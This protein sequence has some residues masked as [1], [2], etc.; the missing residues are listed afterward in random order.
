MPIAAG[1]RF[2]P[3]E[4][5][6]QIGAGGMGEVYRAT[7][8]NLKRDV[9]IKVLPESIAADADRIA[10]FKR[11]AEVLA[12]LNHAHIAQIYGLE[13][14]DDQTVIVMELVDGPTLA[15]RIAAGPVSPDEA[16]GIARQ[17]ANALEAAHSAQVVHRDLK[18]ANVK[19]KP[20][21]TV[22]VLDFGIAKAIDA[23]AISGG[24]TPVTTTPAVTET[25]VILGTAAYMSPEQARGRPVDQRTDI[26]AFGC[27]LFEMLTGQPAFG[28]EDV[29]MT[30][31]R[32]LDRDTDLSSM[33]GTISPAVRHTIELC[34]EKDPRQRLSDIR[35]VQLALDGRLDSGL[36]SSTE[37]ATKPMPLWRRGLPF[38]AGLVLGGAAI[39]SIMW[40]ATEREPVVSRITDSIG[41]LQSQSGLF[42]LSA[43]AAT[44]SRD[45]TRIGYLAGDPVTIHVRRIDEFDA[46]AVPD[47]AGRQVSSPPCF[48]PDGEWIA[49]SVSNSDLRKAPVNGGRGLTLIE[50]VPGVD[51]CDWGND[52]NIYFGTNAGI[53]RVSESG[54]SMETLTAVDSEAGDASHEHPQLL[55]GGKEVLFS[56][57]TGR[58]ELSLLDVA[59]VD[60][61]TKEKTIVIEGVGYATFAPTGPRPGV[62]H[63]VYGRD[64]ALFAAPF[65]LSR[66]TL[67]SVSP[68]LD[69][70]MGV[71][72]LTFASVSDSGTLAYVTGD[73]FTVD[74]TLNWVDRD[75]TVQ[76][77]TDSGRTWGEVSLSPDGQRIASGE[78]DFE[79]LTS[80]L[81]IYE[82]SSRRLTRT[83]FDGFNGSVVWTPNGERLIYAGLGS[84]AAPEPTVRS[85][86]ADGSAPPL[87]IADLERRALFPTSLS[88]DGTALIGTATRV[89]SPAGNADIFLLRLADGTMADAPATDDDLEFPIETSFNE[90]HAT[91]SP[92]GHWLAYA[93]NESGT[94]Q[95]Y[96]V[97]YPG[98]GGKFQVST[99]GGRQPRW[100]PDGGELFYLEGS[101]M[102]VV[103]VETDAGFRAENPEV[104]FENRDL[105]ARSS[106]NPLGFQYAVA[107][108]GESFLMLQTART[109]QTREL[110]IVQNWFE[111][112]ERL[113]PR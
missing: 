81:W 96:V 110:R 18:P 8:T 58:T 71:A 35:D 6:E 2:G 67:G 79:N 44:I 10:R 3:Y 70:V 84:I 43:I 106:A 87:T 85:V 14:T 55:P 23:Q 24:H 97:P 4:I 37:S 78:G 107:P 5:V 99:G 66:R 28:G 80:D 82:F 93:S 51:L 32:V 36:T 61:E 50:D 40:S 19:I 109:G 113:A 15:D 72:G 56:I 20:D 94:E 111:E 48:S 76:T 41:Q 101:R 98:P 25:G 39:A 7:D 69:G 1:T 16:L 17:I 46:A 91:F 100:N 104:L 95:V 21:G 86:P 83:T 108:D 53:A 63:L 90:N 65:D 57:L 64:G 60:L 12:S 62:G 34:L 73:F 38:A 54:G 26:W 112:L 105:I 11:E 49:F 68:V 27:L 75:G 22:K 52:G 31:A 74:P 29:M 89:A 103:R 33:P 102:M 45:G 42:A 77:V 59:I 92:D 9:A 30:L 88:P 47:A 13:N